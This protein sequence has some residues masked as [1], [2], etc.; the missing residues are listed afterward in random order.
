MGVFG[1]VH[2]LRTDFKKAYDSLRKEILY[3]ILNA[4]GIPMKLRKKSVR[5]ISYSEQSKCFIAIT[6]QLYF[7]ICH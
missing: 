2:Q 4:F 7:R 5:C 1:T 6:F 3:N